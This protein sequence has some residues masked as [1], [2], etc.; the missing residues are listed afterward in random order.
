MEHIDYNYLLVGAAVLVAV[1]S[2]WANLWAGFG[3]SGDDEHQR[4]LTKASATLGLFWIYSATII[5]LL[6]LAFILI[7]QYKEGLCQWWRDFFHDLGFGFLIAGFIMAIINMLESAWSV[8][9]KVSCDLTAFD[10]YPGFDAADVNRRLLCE[11]FCI[12]LLLL[13]VSVFGKML[14]P[15]FW[16]GYLLILGYGYYIYRRI[17]SRRPKI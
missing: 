5:A 10:P 6:A 14:D 2:L 7:G 15:W 3:R 16:S 11:I 8:Y 9:H 4:Q 12:V 1:L 17:T 13:A